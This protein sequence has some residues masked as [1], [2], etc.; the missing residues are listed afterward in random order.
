MPRLSSGP[1]HWLHPG[2]GGGHGGR[3]G[4]EQGH[5]R[6]QQPRG[7]KIWDSSMGRQQRCE[8][9][10]QGL[11]WP[12][13][14][15]LGMGS[16][17][18]DPNPPLAWCWAPRAGTAMPGPISSGREGMWE[19]GDV[20]RRGCG[21]EGMWE[22]AFPVTQLPFR[23]HGSQLCNAA[24]TARLPCVNPI[25][26]SWSCF[27]QGKG[28]YQ[29]WLSAAPTS[30]LLLTQHLISFPR[31]P[32]PSSPPL[33]SLFCTGEYPSAF[34]GLHIPRGPRALES[35]QVQIQALTRFHPWLLVPAHCSDGQRV[36]RAKPAAP[37]WVTK[38]THTLHCPPN[39]ISSSRTCQQPRPCLSGSYFPCP[40]ASSPQVP[41]R[42]RAQQEPAGGSRLCCEDGAGTRTKKQELGVLGRGRWQ[43]FALTKGC[44]VREEPTEAPAPNPTEGGT[45]SRDGARGKPIPEAQAGGARNP[46]TR[47]LRDHQPHTGWFVPADSRL[48]HQSLGKCLPGA[49]M[50][51]SHG[52]DPAHP[53]WR[54][55]DG[56]AETQRRGMEGWESRILLGAPLWMRKGFPL[57]VDHCPRAAARLG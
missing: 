40:A 45:D 3:L 55:M 54:W 24:H 31:W 1:L 17:C 8:K 53:G 37:G 6:A 29:P 56:A 48:W 46:G 21:K 33:P 50:D 39:S 41:A 34:Q 49:G 32:A 9:P 16:P 23:L 11:W 42:S 38:P 19:G 28:C 22:G 51:I 36:P 10:A 4:T 12:P 13:E 20:G 52:V 27:L 44:H 57:L 18:S 30:A 7:P 5:A 15:G 2:A 26:I 25:N 35:P 43:E 47:L 14:M